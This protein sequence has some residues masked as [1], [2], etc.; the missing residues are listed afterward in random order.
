MSW[1]FQPWPG[2]TGDL[3][4]TLIRERGAAAFK[5]SKFVVQ[6]WTGP[7]PSDPETIA[8]LPAHRLAALIAAKRSRRRSSRRSISIA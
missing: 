3:M 1:T 8:F 7:V 6:P 4:E 5:R 2:G